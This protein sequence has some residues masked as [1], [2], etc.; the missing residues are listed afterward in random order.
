MLGKCSNVLACSLPFAL[1]IFQIESYAFTLAI[2]IPWP[3]YRYFPSNWEHRCATTPS[4][5]FQIGS[6]CSRVGSNHYAPVPHLAYIFQIWSNFIVIFPLGQR[7]EKW[8]QRS[9][10]LWLQRTGKQKISWAKKRECNTHWETSQALESCFHLWEWVPLLGHIWP[11]LQVAI[12]VWRLHSH[13]VYH[14][15]VTI[16]WIKLY[17]YRF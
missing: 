10:K 11:D 5:F 9:R 4:L 16:T 15:Q 3:C 1:V 7:G 13:R 6:N 8:K 14:R 12:G 17:L 2:L